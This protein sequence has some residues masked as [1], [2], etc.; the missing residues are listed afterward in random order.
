VFHDPKFI[1][2]L[3]G[4]TCPIIEKQNQRKSEKV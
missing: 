4:V 3:T 1:K 2:S